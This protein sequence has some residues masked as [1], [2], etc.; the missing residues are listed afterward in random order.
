MIKMTE[1]PSA[2]YKALKVYEAVG[3]E[4]LM[5]IMVKSRKVKIEPTRLIGKRLDKVDTFGK[6]IIF[7]FSDYAI[8]IHLMMYGT[9][10]I[11]NINEP[12]AKPERLLRLLLKFERK[13][14]AVYN[15]PVI[16]IDYAYNIIKKLKKMLGEDPLRND[17]DPKRAV[18]LILKHK[19]RKIGD[20][21]L[22][23]SVIAGIGNILRNEIL[24]RAR[25]HPERLVKNLS[26]EEIER[27]V[28]VAKELSEE[29]FKRRVNGQRIGPIL[30]VYN[31]YNKPCPICG[32]PIRYYRQSP[33][34]R[35]TFVCD[36]CQK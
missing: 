23:Q 22:D 30:M 20:A 1:G 15:A 33:N 10:H 8:R 14:V 31:K 21:L 3:E 17:W 29:F 18:R 32:N 2:R 12:L 25:V 4:K 34:N 7:I 6:N 9:I 19:N 27:I 35:R 13:K 5:G 26:I 16:E 28:N 11:Y 36:K 24:F